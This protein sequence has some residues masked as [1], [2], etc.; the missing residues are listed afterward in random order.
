[1]N[2]MVAL[3]ER[4]GLLERPITAAWNVHAS[5]EVRYGVKQVD[6]LFHPNCAELLQY[7]PQSDT[8]QRQVIVIDQQVENLFGE[9][10]RSYYDYHDVTCDLLSLPVSEKNKDLELTLH[11]CHHLEAVGVLRRSDRII[12]I[13]GGVL[14]DVVGL[15]ASLYRR[16]IPYIKVP[17]NGMAMWD[18][19][20]GIKT[21]INVFERRN[22]LGS[23]HAPIMALLDRT[24]LATTSARDLSNGMGELLKLSVIKDSDLFG[25]L[26]SH[27]DMLLTSRFQ[28]PVV[29][30]KVI[31]LA[32]NGMLEE[33]APNL[34]E[35]K[36]ERS[37]DF[38]HS[39]APLLEMMAL[40][41]LLHGEAVALDILFSCF[42][43]MRRDLLSEADVQRVIDVMT[44]MRLPIS[45]RF[46]HDPE[47]LNKALSDTIK[48]RDGQQRLPLPSGIGQCIFVNDIQYNEIVLAAQEMENVSK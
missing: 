26:E 42:I 7:L 14:L 9:H 47:L 21:A 44:A 38:G 40:P 25:L 36:L 32:I 29:A 17:T 43:A 30:P 45:H 24:F 18:A 41:E 48:H 6:G 34:W 5:Q 2:D 23:Y 12:A 3:P 8:K 10:I 13:G 31:G 15:A 33:L 46:F 28:D 35:L 27:S 1:M 37:V 19:A 22:R 39:F 4:A 11:I 16:G 20:I